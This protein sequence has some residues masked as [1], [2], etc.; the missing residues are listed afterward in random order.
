MVTQPL[1][2]G[3]LISSARLLTP[4]LHGGAFKFKRRWN[5]GRF[6]LIG[7]GRGSDRVFVHPVPGVMG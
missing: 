1:W 3:E 4:L 6:I 7:E 2:G 5:F